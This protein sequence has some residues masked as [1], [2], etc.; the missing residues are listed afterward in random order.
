MNVGVKVRKKLT[1]TRKTMTV[2][3]QRRRD[4]IQF[5]SRVPVRWFGSSSK[6]RGKTGK[7]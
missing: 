7:K 2:Q 3:T 4:A 5:L 6:K 1:R